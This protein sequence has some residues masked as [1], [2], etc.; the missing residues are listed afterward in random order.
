M[1]RGWV[2][3]YRPDKRSAWRSLTAYQRS[4]WLELLMWT[5]HR[6]GIAT[7]G[8]RELAENAQ[9]TLTTAFDA[10]RKMMRLGM[11]EK[12]ENPDSKSDSDSDSKS[13]T[14]FGHQRSSF[15]W[16]RWQEEQGGME[17]VATIHSDTSTD[18]R[19][20]SGTDQ[21]RAL[22]AST[23]NKK[24][25]TAKKK[26]AKK[27]KADS[28]PSLLPE[29]ALSLRQD[30]GV[31]S[32][33]IRY[34]AYHLK[35]YMARLGQEMSPV[36]FVTAKRLVEK[37]AAPD[38]VIARAFVGVA[39]FR[40]GGAARA[41]AKANDGKFG[42]YTR[43]IENVKGELKRARLEWQRSSAGVLGGGE[44]P[45]EVE[46]HP[47]WV[48]GD[49]FDLE[50]CHRALSD[51]RGKA[52]MLQNLPRLDLGSEHRTVGE[53]GPVGGAGDGSGGHGDDDLGPF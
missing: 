4:V 34:L 32:D 44:G 3:V 20:D 35:S 5:D 13:D 27:A 53:T 1:D 26:P 45:G 36:D 2:K 16:L 47:H 8:R 52:G 28:Q 11:I 51:L 18:S 48:R 40:M 33:P 42:D 14:L 46:A 29:S 31:N 50:A 19:S 39:Y 10:L 7:I 43:E 15:K 21:E 38:D 9:V 24:T 22:T 37:G 25:T 17:G 49:G 12:V 41:L 30:D 6:T 23:K